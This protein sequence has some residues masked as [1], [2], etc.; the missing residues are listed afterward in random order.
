[1]RRHQRYVLLACVLIIG[2]ALFCPSLQ[3]LRINLPT[4]APTTKPAVEGYSVADELRYVSPAGIAYGRDYSGKFPSR[5][6]HIM[7]HTM[8]DASKP[9]HSVF[10]AK[11]RADVLRLLDEAWKK[12]GPPTQQGGARGR[13]VYDVHMHRPIGTEGERHIRMVMERDSS[14]IITAYPIHTGAR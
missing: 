8:P 10:K 12:R 9:K 13:D 11:T 2:C 6:A 1:M 3:P 4:T 5:I 7:A 14:T